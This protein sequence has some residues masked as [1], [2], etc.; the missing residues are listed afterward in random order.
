M[1]QQTVRNHYLPQMYLKNWSLDGNTIFMYNRLVSHSDVPYWSKKFIK[2]TAYNHHLYTAM[3]NSTITDK[4]EKWLQ[5][6]VENPAKESLE[7]VICGKLLSKADMSNLLRFTAVQM[8][9]TPAYYYDKYQSVDKAVLLDKAADN[10][11]RDLKERIT[12][13]KRGEI[14]QISFA[15]K[16]VKR[17]VNVKIVDRY[18][19]NVYVEYSI[20][21]GRMA[22]LSHI[23]YATKNILLPLFLEQQW[24]VIRIHQSIELPTSDNP[25]V[26][27]VM[28]LQNGVEILF[29]LSPH[30]LL[31]CM[32]GRKFSDIEINNLQGN[33]KFSR[34]V[35]KLILENSFLYVYSKE[36]QKGMFSNCPRTIDELQFKRINQMMD[37]W[38]NINLSAEKNFFDKI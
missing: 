27:T 23:E 13:I 17:P 19:Q 8:V 7:K 20:L 14:P 36:K 38:H 18:E 32:I 16:V 21:E 4:F 2:H 12:S 3:E 35:W 24:H 6:D 10:L 26:L 22:W 37:D 25:V 9:R 1:E 33:E 29:P 31:Y 15:N 34:L 5:H 11:A 30:F 28:F